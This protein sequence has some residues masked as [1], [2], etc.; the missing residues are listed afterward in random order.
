MFNEI[1]PYAL[2][3]MTDVFG[4]YVIQKFF[5]FGSC[6]QKTALVRKLRGHVL[7][8]ALQMYGCR[9]IQ[10]AM[11]TVNEE[12]QLEVATELDGHIIT[13]IQ[14]QNGNHVVQK[15]IETVPSGSLDF[16]IKAVKGQVMP[17]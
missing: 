16:V 7:Q 2:P 8:L 9:V 11:E 5:D 15:C 6:E 12:L 13:C 4:N 3:L 14:D 10:K 1:I 17:L